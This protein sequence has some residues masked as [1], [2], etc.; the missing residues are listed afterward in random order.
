MFRSLI[1][2]P[3]GSLIGK[4][5]GSLIEEASGSLV[6]EI[7]R[8]LIKELFGCST[9]EEFFD[10]GKLTFLTAEKKL[11]KVNANFKPLKDIFWV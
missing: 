9:A 10:C 11:L 8:S 6:K 5:F 7:F 4:P 2:E 3:F 1:K